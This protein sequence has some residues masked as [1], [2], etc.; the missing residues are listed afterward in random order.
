MYMYTFYTVFVLL[1]YYIYINKKYNI[2][3]IIYL[4]NIYVYLFN[5]LIS[6]SN[7]MIQDEQFLWGWKIGRTR[8]RFHPYR[9]RILES[10]LRLRSAKVTRA[11]SA[12]KVIYG[13]WDN[14]WH[15]AGM[16]DNHPLPADVLSGAIR[17]YSR[18]LINNRMTV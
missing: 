14:L 5:T 4:F 15:V 11:E 18:S 13:Q 12:A 3:L 2:Y 1:D 7:E 10:E 16:I 17:T 8:L 9:Y 6:W